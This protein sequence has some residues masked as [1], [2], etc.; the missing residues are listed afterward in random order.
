MLSF[1]KRKLADPPAPRQHFVGETHLRQERECAPMKNAGMAMRGGL[2]L[3]VNH[4]HLKAVFGQYKSRQ[5]S[6]R[7]RA[8]HQYIRLIW[9]HNM[10]FYVMVVMHNHR[11]LTGF[12]QMLALFAR[13]H[14]RGGC[15]RA[16]R[17]FAGTDHG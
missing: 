12:W 4:L 9:K 13:D 17:D 10:P 2:L 16:T 1:I 15:A 8:D 6:D 5:H 3:F 11:H 7:S 14:G